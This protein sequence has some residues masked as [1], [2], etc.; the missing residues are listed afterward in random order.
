M[1][2]L[3]KNKGTI[4]KILQIIKNKSVKEQNKTVQN[5]ILK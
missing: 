2:P 3:N 4:H 5:K 1:L